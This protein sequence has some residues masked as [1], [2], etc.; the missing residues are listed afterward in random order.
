MRGYAFGA[1][2]SP[3]PTLRHR[4]KVAD[5]SARVRLPPKLRLPALIAGCTAIAWLTWCLLW[6]GDEAIAQSKND[7]GLAALSEI[8]SAETALLEP[9]S[10]EGQD[11]SR[12]AATAEPAPGV[13]TP[14]TGPELRV[15][16]RGLRPELPWTGLVQWQVTAHDAAGLELERS[17]QHD[18]ATTG[19]VTFQLPACLR[20]MSS[21]HGWLMGTDRN[22]RTTEVRWQG[23]ATD[24]Q[25]L[26]LDVF[27][28]ASIVGRVTG[29]RGEQLECEVVA[30][31]MHDGAP[32]NERVGATTTHF[33]SFRL[34]VPAAT[35]VFV[36][37]APTTRQANP[38]L[39]WRSSELHPGLLPSGQ[40]T[41]GRLGADTDLGTLALEPAEQMQGRVEFEDGT[42]VPGIRV[43]AHSGGKAPLT[44]FE[45]FTIFEDGEG[46][47]HS[48]QL[49]EDG[50]L[51]FCTNTT[52]GTDGTFSLPTLPGSRTSVRVADFGRRTNA[53]VVG[54]VGFELFTLR[55]SVVL[56]IP[57]LQTIRVEEAGKC[58]PGAF[59]ELRRSANC[60]EGSGSF[61]KF[62]T[63]AQG[64]LQLA[65]GMPL[66]VRASANGMQSLWTE[67]WDHA[68]RTLEL[69]TA[70][71]ELLLD[72][73][74]R[75]GIDRIR[76]ES[77]RENFGEVYRE[78][79][80]APFHVHLPLGSHQIRIHGGNYQTDWLLP[81]EA[82]VTV[83]STPQH[84][85]LPA[86]A[87]GRLRV[88]LMDDGGR[89]L[90]GT[91]K[92]QDANGTDQT[93]HF[94]VRNYLGASIAQ[95]EPA[96]LL[97]GG[98]NEGAELLTPGVYYLTVEAQGQ[99]V[100][101]QQVKINALETTEVHLRLQ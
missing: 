92:V 10:S 60:C 26:I 87:G 47:Q 73:D 58:V 84:L 101:F 99:H 11:R 94:E 48:V 81:I 83:T 55:R 91:C 29:P 98:A 100:A 97:R 37:V 82:T 42:P 32:T 67:V 52:T 61:P 31:A 50:R 68:P 18:G 13:T 16:L 86:P 36:V 72:F 5:Y 76:V 1:H 15:R 75:N 63:D 23:G 62:Y 28:Q 19:E 53:H 74:H 80:D 56:R 46:R 59:V 54:S 34:L 78:R 39:S 27:P 85:T 9:S 17:G 77:S 66:E 45:E 14:V 69:Q 93:M 65:L 3:R 43:W 12:A 25:E 90:P 89:H 35:P 6:P 30:F 49:C 22:Y 95:G 88:F 40:A 8:D 57:K 2:S 79:R 33:D 64:D 51:G 24:T 21:A 20:G 70:L 44:I 38:W 4:T 41:M 96:E 7:L 71:G